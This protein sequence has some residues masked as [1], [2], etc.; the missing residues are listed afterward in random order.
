M[1]K[2]MILYFISAITFVS[3][4]HAQ[5]QWRFH[6]AFEDATGAK[7]T[8][9]ML[10]DTTAHGPLPTDT[11]LGEGPFNFNHNIF[12]VWVYNYDN[13]STKT[14]A[15]PYLYYPNHSVSIHAFNFQ[16][17][18]T[19]RWDTSLIHSPNLPYQQGLI[20]QATMHN[21][22]FFFVNN[23]PLC[24]CFDMLQIDTAIAPSYN[25]FSQSQ[26]PLD[27]YLEQAPLSQY[28]IPNHKNK[29]LIEP[30]PF[31]DYITINAA[32]SN[33]HLEIYS[34]ECQKVYDKKVDGSIEKLDLRYLQNGIYI[35]K[36]INNLKIIQYEKIIKVN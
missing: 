29:I 14:W 28:E 9:W 11:A 17:P 32:G 13:D 19:I 18:L 16:Y 31:I 27:I 30:N 15:L 20:N 2:N 26:F 3:V 22:Y 23:Y 35:L 5:P 34:M 12:N 10:Y 24:G 21:D 4:A 1:I 36:I 7:D 6:I 25:W 8:I 33:T